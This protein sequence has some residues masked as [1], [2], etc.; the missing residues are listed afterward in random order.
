[1]TNAPRQ[2]GVPSSRARETLFSP[3]SYARVFTCQV[4]ATAA[5]CLLACSLASG[6]T[7]GMN[8]GPAVIVTGAHAW[9]GEIFARFSEFLLLC[10]GSCL[11]LLPSGLMV[12]EVSIIMERMFFMLEGEAFLKLN[13]NLDVDLKLTSL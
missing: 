13:C 9:S 2:W 1:M 10:L 5:A 7:I 8:Y 12:I 4:A 11:S 6:F 3:A